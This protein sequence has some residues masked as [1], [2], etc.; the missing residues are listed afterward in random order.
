MSYFLI[1]SFAPIK[2]D[3]EPLKVICFSRYHN[4]C[5]S[6]VLASSVKLPKQLYFFPHASVGKTSFRTKLVSTELI[7]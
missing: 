1:H 4:S 7:M 3:I 2:I 5:R 6:Q